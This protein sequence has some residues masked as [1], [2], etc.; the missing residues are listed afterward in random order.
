MKLRTEQNLRE[1][2]RTW[3][4]LQLLAILQRVGLFEHLSE[5]RSMS[6]TH[7]AERLELD[8]RM[9]GAAL[10]VLVSSELLVFDPAGYRLARHARPILLAA[11]E[12]SHE[13][14]QLP[15]FDEALRSGQPLE[16]TVG[17]VSVGDQDEAR[18]FMTGLHRRSQASVPEVLRTVRHAW[19][20][21]RSSRPGP[22]ILDLG[23]GHGCF[24]A[25][26]ARELPGAESTLFDQPSLLAI[27]ESLSGTGYRHIGGDYLKDP[28]GGPY[29]VIFMSNILHG[30]SAAVARTLLRRV[31]EE[32]TPRGTLVLRDRF[33]HDDRTGPDYVADF[34]IT[35]TLNTPAGRPR[36]LCEAIETLR[37]V[38]FNQFEKHEA[39]REE[40]GYLVATAGEP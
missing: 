22:R 33:L 12:S 8:P 34:A 32:L 39:A 5:D 28:L 10:D 15:R 23:G 1:A 3:R 6:A 38:G 37:A 29:D 35:L 26:F 4:S 14:E 31:R 9:L 18:R 13:F 16:V 27:A 20:R 24:A 19:D 21:Q 40:Y 11:A 17:G 36:T 2:R 25:A 30:E 7:L